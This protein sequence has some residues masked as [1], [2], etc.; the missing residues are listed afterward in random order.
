MHVSVDPTTGNSIMGAAWR[1]VHRSVDGTLTRT[2]WMT[3]VYPELHFV[4]VEVDTNMDGDTSIAVDP[5]RDGEH[6]CWVC[7]RK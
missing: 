2:I 1:E 6:Q 4:K 7:I 5:L 3:G